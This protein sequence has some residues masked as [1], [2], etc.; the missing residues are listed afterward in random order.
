MKRG[1][2][3]VRE[4]LRERVDRTASGSTPIARSG[5]IV[6]LD[7]DTGRVIWTDRVNSLGYSTPAVGSD[8]IF[9]GDFNGGLRA[10]EK[11]NGR[12][13]WRAHVGGRI[14]GAPVIVGDLVF[15]ST[16]ETETYA[17]RASDGKIVWRYGL[18]KYSPG[19]ATERAYYFSLNGMLVAF[20]GARRP[21]A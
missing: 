16:L 6:A 12:L 19:I 17:A 21:A 10:Y 15:F 5:R 20:R 11:T 14:L 1:H 7:A 2:V 4:L 3:P 8:R 13:L 9:V 18:G